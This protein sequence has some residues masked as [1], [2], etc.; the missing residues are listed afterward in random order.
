M[1]EPQARCRA[2]IEQQFLQH[3]RLAV[4]EIIAE[5]RRKFGLH[6]NVVMLIITEVLR[7][8]AVV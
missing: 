8:G 7:E 1:E 4:F 2:W 6:E 5:A 3:K